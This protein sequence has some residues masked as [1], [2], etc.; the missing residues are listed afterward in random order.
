L[1][2]ALEHQRKLL[3]HGIKQFEVTVEFLGS[4]A[5]ISNDILKWPLIKG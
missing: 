1:P 5:H 4:I 2:L 3:G